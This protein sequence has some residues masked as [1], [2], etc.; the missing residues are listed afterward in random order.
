[1]NVDDGKLHSDAMLFLCGSGYTNNK[2]G[3]GTRKSRENSLLFFV[4]QNT[5]K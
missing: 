2:E 4:Q 5:K 3:D 1:M